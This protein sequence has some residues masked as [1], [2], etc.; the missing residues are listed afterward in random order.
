[1][2]QILGVYANEVKRIGAGGGTRD[3]SSGHYQI[4]G[5]DELSPSF[6]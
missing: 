6:P 3:C 4:K 5:N 1:M 2:L